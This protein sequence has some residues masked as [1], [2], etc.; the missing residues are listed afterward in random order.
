VSEL[1]AAENSQ[2]GPDV[3]ISPT[4]PP[5]N[6]WATP[7]FIKRYNLMCDAMLFRIESSSSHVHLGKSDVESWA[8][9]TGSSYRMSDDIEPDWSRVRILLD[10]ASFIMDYVDFL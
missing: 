8:N 9:A 5:D 1:D 7:N 10:E 2:H 6:D 4:P 3:W